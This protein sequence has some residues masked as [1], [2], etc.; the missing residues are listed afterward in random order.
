[1]CIVQLFTR[2][3]LNVVRNGLVGSLWCFIIE[4]A[5]VC[6]HGRGYNLIY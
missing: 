3:Y 2:I 4:C 1:M 6:R 5:Q